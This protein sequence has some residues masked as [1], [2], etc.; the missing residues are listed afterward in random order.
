MAFGIPACSPSSHHY[1]YPYHYHYHY[2]IT[3]K[4]FKVSCTHN[5]T[6]GKNVP[7]L[8]MLDSDNAVEKNKYQLE[9]YRVNMTLVSVICVFFF[10]V[11]LPSKCSLT[12]VFLRKWFH[13]G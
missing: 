9:F 5:D 8:K 1:H 2:H 12:E 11:L 3:L 4:S 13:E 7:V 6:L 10:K